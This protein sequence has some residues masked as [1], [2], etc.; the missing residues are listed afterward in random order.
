MAIAQ[1]SIYF[2]QS[3]ASVQELEIQKWIWEF[4]IGW[5]LLHPLY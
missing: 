4:I 3:A 2:L 5:I 1:H